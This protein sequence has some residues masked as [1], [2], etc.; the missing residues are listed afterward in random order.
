MEKLK[1]SRITHLTNVVILILGLI[2]ALGIGPLHPITLGIYAAFLC[3]I[4]VFRTKYVYLDI[5]VAVFSISIFVTNYCYQNGIVG[6]FAFPSQIALIL[7]AT[8]LILCV[9]HFL[10]NLNY[11]K[12]S[13]H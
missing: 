4:W 12:R 6:S 1:K 2:I 5:M 8:S 10:F 11:I 3:F 13:N 7:V 9:I